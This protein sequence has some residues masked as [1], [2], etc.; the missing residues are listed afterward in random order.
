MKAHL[1]GCRHV[2]DPLIYK[3]SCPPTLK[4][5]TAKP[6]SVNAICLTV[7]GKFIPKVLVS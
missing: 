4:S 1:F 3:K 7:S 5:R 6:D 2:A